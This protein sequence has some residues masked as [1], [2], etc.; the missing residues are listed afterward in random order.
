MAP[1]YLPFYVSD[2]MFTIEVCKQYRFWTNFFAQRKKKQFIQLPWKVGEIMVKN[3][4]KIDEFVV[5]FEPHK[6][7][8]S[9]YVKGF[10][11][12]HFFMNHI[13]STGLVSHILT[14]TYMR[15]RRT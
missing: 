13:I 9:N 6:L 12:Q 2:K 15:M 8:V 1:T 5:Q 10:D 3:A 11:P 14:H 4:S 7:K